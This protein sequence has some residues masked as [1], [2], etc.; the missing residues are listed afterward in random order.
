MLQTP[1]VVSLVLL[2]GCCLVL[3]GIAFERRSRS[4]DSSAAPVALLD[5]DRQLIDSLSSRQAALEATLKTFSTE[6]KA[7]QTEWEDFYSKGRKMLGRLTRERGWA[8]AREGKVNDAPPDDE[9]PVTRREI[10][11]RARS[12]RH[13]Q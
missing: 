1:L 3:L 10:L 4:R 7:L 13:A 11:R 12:Q 5:S 8:E 2:T 9:T 6:L